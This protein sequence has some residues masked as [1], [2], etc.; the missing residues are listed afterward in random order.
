MKNLG[1]S[2]IEL[3]V[4]FVI[5]SLIALAMFKTVIDL[6][7]QI[8][9]YE[10]MSEIAIVR[11]TVLNDVKKD[12]IQRKIYGVNLCGC[13]C[14]DI[15]FQ[16]LNVKRLIVNSEEK[17]IKYGNKAE[18]LP[19]GYYFL[20]NL[21]N[22][23]DF[24]TYKSTTLTMPV[25]KYNTILNIKVAIR[26]LKDNNIYDINIIHQYDN[27]QTGYLPAFIQN[28]TGTCD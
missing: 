26:N 4:S 13:S 20:Y 17:T 22:I 28:N 15:V 1:F 2:T 12:L 25:L 23:N 14:L 19:D 24:I 5:I 11:G 9:Q 3:L 27:R 10:K 8:D 6:T 16:D 18:R 7:D 21:M